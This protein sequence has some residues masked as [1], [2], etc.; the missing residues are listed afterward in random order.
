MGKLVAVAQSLLDILKW[1]MEGSNWVFVLPLLLISLFIMFKMVRKKERFLIFIWYAASVAV[2]SLMIE[3][4]LGSWEACIF[5]LFFAV[6]YLIIYIPYRKRKSRIGQ[7]G[8]HAATFSSTD[9]PEQSRR[10]RRRR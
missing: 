6:L 4:A 7:K 9:S 8:R 3:L 1:L 10:A 5:A 2:A